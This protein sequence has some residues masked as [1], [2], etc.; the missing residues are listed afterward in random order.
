MRGNASNGALSIPT[1]V[2]RVDGTYFMRPSGITVEITDK[3]FL[4]SCER[5]ESE[6]RRGL[7]AL[8]PPVA[9][10]PTPTVVTI[11]PP[12]TGQPHVIDVPI[13]TYDFDEGSTV[14]VG[15]QR[16][17]RMGSWGLLAVVGVG[18]V[19]FFRKRKRR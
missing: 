11:Q 2:G 4:L 18:A 10:T 6:L 3:P 14:T 8:P 16:T 17:N 15:S 5:I 9:A 19:L 7:A 13:T 12:P 1:S